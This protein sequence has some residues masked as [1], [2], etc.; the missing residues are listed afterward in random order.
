[1]SPVEPPSADPHAHPRGDALAPGPAGSEDPRRMAATWGVPFFLGLLLVA[2]GVFCLIVATLTSLASIL[3]LG[4]LLVVAGILEVIHG[5]RRRK[6]GAF[7]L[8]LLGGLLSVVVGV[9]MVLQPLVGL[10]AVTL[11]LAGYFLASGLF[12]GFTS[13]M[14]RYPGWGWDCFYGVVSVVLGVLLFTQ[15]PTASLWLVGTLVGVELFARGIAL[16]GA[17]MALRKLLRTRLPPPASTP[18]ATTSA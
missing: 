6:G 9:M 16:M 10:V 15:L 18:T 13:V 3:V 2:M 1:M 4:S 11:L 7:F 17:A 14:D 8:F 5:F 12:R